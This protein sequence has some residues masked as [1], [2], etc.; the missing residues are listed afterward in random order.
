MREASYFGRRPQLWSCIP[1]EL[2]IRRGRSKVLRKEHTRDPERR[3]QRPMTAMM[4]AS[5][6]ELIHHPRFR[7]IEE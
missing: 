5:G 4:P 6:I 7:R 1:F 2:H 3:C